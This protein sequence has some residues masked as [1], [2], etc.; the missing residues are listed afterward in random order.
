[1]VDLDDVERLASGD[2]YLA[3]F[4]VGSPNGRVQA[5]VVNAGVHADPVDGASGVAAVVGGGTHKLYLLR[6][7]GQA[8]SSSRPAGSGWRCPG[9][10]GSSVRTT[11][12]SSVWM[13][14]H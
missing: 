13:C 2:S 3:V 11:A 6:R 14:R 7:V 10:C 8:T 12:P 5:S 4:T 1:M 9:P